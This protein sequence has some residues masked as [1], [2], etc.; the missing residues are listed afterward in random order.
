MTTSLFTDTITLYNHY[1]HGREKYWQ[2][3]VLR[4][5][6]WKQKIVHTASDTG[7]VVVITETSVTIPVDVDANWRVY[8]RPLEFSMAEDKENLWTLSPADGG[9]LMIYGEC[10]TEISGDVTADDL[11]KLGAVVVKA[12]KDNTLRQYLKHWKVVAI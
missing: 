1:R 4:G 12:A 9:D 10:M 6:Q 8:V 5:V 7:S 2:R 3:T 11:C